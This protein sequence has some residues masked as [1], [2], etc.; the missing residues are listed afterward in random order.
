SKISC[1]LHDGTNPGKR[2]LRSNMRTPR[3]AVEGGSR[4]QVDDREPMTYRRAASLIAHSAYGSCPVVKC[5]KPNG[6]DYLCK[7][8]YSHLP[9]VTG[10]PSTSKRP[11]DRSE[12]IRH[13]RR[14]TPQGQLPQ[15]AEPPGARRHLGHDGPAQ[16]EP[17]QR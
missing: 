11:E 16:E 1:R 8:L 2:I 4:G 5:S 9:A 3:V 6:N 17:D 14:G 13:T 15:P 7:A 12:E 10:K